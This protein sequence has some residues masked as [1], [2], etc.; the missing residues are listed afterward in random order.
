MEHGAC[1]NSVS[2]PKAYLVWSNWCLCTVE[3]ITDGLWNLLEIAL[4]N[5]D[6]LTNV[7]LNLAVRNSS[8]NLESAEL[9]EWMLGFLYY[10]LIEVN[11]SWPLVRQNP[12]EMHFTKR[13]VI[14]ASF[15]FKK[16]KT[17]IQI[18]VQEHIKNN[19]I[20]DLSTLQMS[21]RKVSMM[22]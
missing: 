2:T 16:N 14:D 10:Q 1:Q 4:L 12:R 13:I 19:K 11:S 3:I 6:N 21:C 18:N 8:I 9:L 15:F 17:S 20:S 5:A 7:I 22:E